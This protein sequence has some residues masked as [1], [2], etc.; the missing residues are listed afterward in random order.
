MLLQE[1]KDFNHILSIFCLILLCMF[2]FTKPGKSNSNIFQKLLSITWIYYSYK[3]F[4]VDSI[5]NLFF[6]GVQDQQREFLIVDWIIGLSSFLVGLLLFLNYIKFF[7]SFRFTQGV[8]SRLAIIFNFFILN[9][10]Y[11][12]FDFSYSK[13]Q[14]YYYFKQSSSFGEVFNFVFLVLNLFPLIFNSLVNEKILNMKNLKLFPNIF[15]I[16]CFT[17]FL[18]SFKHYNYNNT[19][20]YWMVE[21]LCCFILAVRLINDLLFFKFTL[22]H[23][24]F[25]ILAVLNLFVLYGFPHVSDLN[26]NQ[27]SSITNAISFQ[28][29]LIRESLLVDAGVEGFYGI[30]L[31]ADEYS[32]IAND[33]LELS[34]QGESLSIVSLKEVKENKENET[35][36]DLNK[37]IR[38]MTKN[39]NSKDFRL[40]FPKYNS[41]T[42]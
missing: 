1:E 28:G 14:E 21:I 10:N 25:L 26:I 17:L 4:I 42:I 5:I 7:Q 24:F 36:E 31:F 18:M 13:I 8:I 37:N 15:S 41:F 34:F 39:V 32:T 19:S 38:C 2:F 29:F 40:I 11:G 22:H 6:R 23:F 27:P 30:D 35:K 12:V 33:F 20:L 9:I 3:T 16:S